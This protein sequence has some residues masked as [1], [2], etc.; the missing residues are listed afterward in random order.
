VDFLDMSEI[1]RH[2]KIY[3]ITHINN[4]EGILSNKV[5]WSDAK[6]LEL[7][8]DCEIVGMSEIKRRRLKELEV[9]CHP[10]T[11]VGEYVPFY[12]CPRSIMLYILYMGNHPDIS[13]REGQ[14]PIVHLQ[15]DLMASIQW[16]EKHKVRWA[17]SDRNAGER[18][19][20]FYNDVNKLN[21][22]NWSAMAA[23]DW[24]DIIIQEGK[25]AEFLMYESF[26][27]ELIEKIGIHNNAVGKSVIE[28]VGKSQADMVMIE[29]SWYY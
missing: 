22:V 11:K 24:R 3:H 8:L 10:G 5:L 1:P 14:G 21:R 9:D 29:K 7:G 17:F 19:A 27:W 26:P 2:P 4:L 15:A 23:T 16:A 25:Q 20:N 12:F 18:I 13:Y 28:K 6:R